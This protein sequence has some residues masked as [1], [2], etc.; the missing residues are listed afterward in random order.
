[1]NRIVSGIGNIVA[2]V[3][4]D[5]VIKFQVETNMVYQERIQL[6]PFFDLFRIHNEGMAFS[7][8][9]NAEPWLL[10]TI[11]CGVIAFVFWLWRSSPQER[12]ISHLGFGMI[13]GGAVGN[14]I[15]RATLGYVVDMFLFYL[16]NWSFA[17][18]NFADTCITVGAGLIFLDEL[19]SWRR[20]KKIDDTPS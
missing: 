18:F 2:M 3:V 12:W 8:L 11:A 16:E 20:S 13:I 7:M 6:L 9:S 1:M 19:L 10:F 5:Q 14:I 15:D 4:I 17:V